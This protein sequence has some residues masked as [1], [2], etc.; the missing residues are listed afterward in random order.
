VE[1]KDIIVIGG[2]PSGWMSA[3]V[4]KKEYGEKSVLLIRAE[5][6]VLIPCA[7]PYI[8]RRIGT[9]DKNLL[10]DEPLQK[11]DVEII[12]GKVNS[13]NRENKTITLDKEEFEYD[14]LILAIGASPIVPKLEGKDLENVYT[15]DK[16]PDYIRELSNKLKSAK[17][18]LIVGGGY[19]GIE[20]ADELRK[21]GS[22]VTIVEMM[23][24]CLEAAHGEEYCNLAQEEL[25]KTGVQLRVNKK[26]MRFMGNGKV[27]KVV[28]DDGEEIECDLVLL[29][30]GAKPNA[31]LAEK[32]GVKTSKYGICVNEYMQTSDPDIFAIGDCAETFSFFTKKPINLRLASIAS[33]EARI[34]GANLYEKRR[35]NEG[36]IAV[37]STC[38]GQP[39]VCFGAAGMNETEAKNADFEYYS[40]EM[41]TIDKHPGAV[42]EARK[43]RIKLL[44]EKATGYLI[45]GQVTGGPTSAEILNSIAALIDGR[46]NIEDVIT[47]QAG[48]HPLNTPSPLTYPLNRA[49]EDAK[50][51]NMS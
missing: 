11:A 43:M 1:K 35:K 50:Y 10:S 49:A 20:F 29:A 13:I 44:F 46:K 3:F 51:S 5:E 38:I 12:N 31:E 37:Y 7:I 34:A 4:A 48:T 21:N 42:G 15:I 30:I 33:I 36:A 32:A 19:I 28:L 2:G 39:G 23:A 16:D 8:F 47:F 14:K 18:V 41:T 40:G 25:Q 45:G 9:I 22:N 6:K 27:E 24:H 26:A 17:N